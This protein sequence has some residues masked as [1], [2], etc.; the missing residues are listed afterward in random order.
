[1]W[2]VDFKL[3]EG[4]TE[5]KETIEAILLQLGIRVHQV[6]F[7]KSEEGVFARVI[8]YS[9][10][11]ETT[12]RNAYQKEDSILNFFCDQTYVHTPSSK[13]EALRDLQAR[14]EQALKKRIAKQARKEKAADPAMRIKKRQPR[15]ASK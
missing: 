11:D 8:L 2:V 3:V 15:Q 6:Y 7:V 9:Q 10:H 1:M 14:R 13:S 12:L 5:T 4:S